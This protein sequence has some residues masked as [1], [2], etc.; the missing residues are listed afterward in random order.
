MNL[1]FLI[2]RLV[3][4]TETQSRKGHSALGSSFLINRL[5]ESTETAW[6][7]LAALNELAS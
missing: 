7:P 6:V 3:E 4:S 1:A 5:V 2:N